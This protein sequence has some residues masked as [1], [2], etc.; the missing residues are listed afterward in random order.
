MFSGEEGFG[1]FLDLTTQHEDYLNLP[2][3][4]RL[5]YTQY[6]EVFDSFVPPHLLIKR[7]NKI[8]DRYFNYVGELATYLENFIK[9][10]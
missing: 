10:T 5:P 6:L 9:K 1:Q 2:G 4:K 3:A 7:P 8:S